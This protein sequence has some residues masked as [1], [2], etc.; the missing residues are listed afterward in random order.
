MVFVLFSG[1]LSWEEVGAES[2]GAELGRRARGARPE[3]VLAELRQL[4]QSSPKRATDVVNDLLEDLTAH[5]ELDVLDALL[6][7]LPALQL[8]LDD[9]SQ[10]VLLESHLALGNFYEVRSLA[11]R[12]G[13]RGG[14]TPRIQRAR[15]DLAL[16]TACAGEA[17]EVLV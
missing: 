12:L 17:V 1:T 14:L 10:E 8:D 9:R 4:L 13:A 3:D 15:L 6:A 16:E 11:A 7:E 5:F 2:D